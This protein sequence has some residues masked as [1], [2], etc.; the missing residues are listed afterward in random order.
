MSK[1][2]WRSNSLKQEIAEAI[3]QFD[4]RNV[5]ITLIMAITNG[6]AYWMRDITYYS[7]TVKPALLLLIFPVIFNKKDTSIVIYRGL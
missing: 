6:L 3:F 4:G 2:N 7:T 1:K 5:I